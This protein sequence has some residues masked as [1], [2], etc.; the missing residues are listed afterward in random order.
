MEDIAEPKSPFWNWFQL[1]LIC[2]AVLIIALAS[3]L[4]L[5][6]KIYLGDAGILAQKVVLAPT[7]AGTLLEVR[8]AEGQTIASSTVVAKVGEQLIKS[9]NGGMVTSISA[10]VGEIVY[11]GTPI[12]TTI[13]PSNV[14]I[15]TELHGVMSP[16][17]AVGDKAVF[18]VDGMGG[19]TYNGEIVRVDP[20]TPIGSGLALPEKHAKQDYKV[21]VSFDTTK[22][23]D[24]KDGMHA[25]VWAYR[26]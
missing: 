7:T 25:K 22:Y 17:I 6:R 4:L 15:Q 12:V 10:A 14:E 11:A 20:V 5:S 23:T 26:W 1:A 13:D 18:T 8:V 3:F 19:K 9:T 24:L 21:S 16:Q 2:G